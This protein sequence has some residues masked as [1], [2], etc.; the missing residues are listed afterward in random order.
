MCRCPGFFLSFFLFLIYSSL[1]VTGSVNGTLPC[2]WPW[3]CTTN[4]H[5]L[6]RVQIGDAHQEEDEEEQE[7]SPE[8]NPQRWQLD[9]R[10]DKTRKMGLPAQHVQGWV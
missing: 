4:N 7:T 6:R 8:I 5:N 10:D 1:N 9:P 3:I 2:T